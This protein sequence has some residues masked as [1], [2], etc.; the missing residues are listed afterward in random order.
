LSARILQVLDAVRRGEIAPEAAMELLVNGDQTDLGFAVIDDHR[1]VRTGIPEVVFGQGKTPEQL[2]GIFE[3]LHARHH[4]AL[5]TRVDSEKAAVV[6]ASLPDATYEP[7]PRL[8]W[9][10]APGT[11]PFETTS[12]RPLWVVSAGTSD[13]PVAEEAARC[14]EWF[15]LEVHRAFDVGVAGLHRVLAR[16]EE[17]ST[18]HA[19][20][21]VAGMEGA[22]P[23]VVAGLV[24]IPVI[25]VPTSVGYGTHLGG[26]V[27]LLA[28]LNSCASGVTVVNVDNGFGAALVAWRILEG[29]R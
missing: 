12:D 29:V 8:L 24:R 19:I 25:A 21:V 28:M 23:S 2:V 22:L 16:A 18:A 6:R 13:L 20:I 3:H 15:G 4:P 17:L 27:P 26:L 7:V 1:P 14:A 10:A 9:R 5:S 11:T